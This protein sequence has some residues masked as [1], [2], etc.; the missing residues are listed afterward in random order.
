MSRPNRYYNMAFYTFGNVPYKLQVENSCGAVRFMKMENMYS[1]A[2]F[3][4]M[5]LSISMETPFPVYTSWYYVQTKSKE[6]LSIF[7]SV[8]QILFF[9]EVLSP[10]MS[11]V[12]VSVKEGA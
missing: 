7:L 4:K 6:P 12:M 5:F 1:V 10:V 2:T 9:V 8:F 3:L 11:S